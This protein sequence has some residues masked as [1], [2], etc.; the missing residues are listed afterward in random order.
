MSRDEVKATS[1]GWKGGH[2]ELR[3]EGKEMTRRNQL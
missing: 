3:P 2:G 1:E